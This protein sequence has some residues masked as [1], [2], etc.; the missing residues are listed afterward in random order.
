REHPWVLRCGR[1][2]KCGAEFHV[3]ELYPDLFNDWSR[4]YP[5]TPQSA[6]ATADAYLRDGRGFDLKMLKG[7]YTQESYFDQKTHAAS[8]T[9]RFALGGDIAWERLI[10]RPERFGSMKARFAGK[11]GGLWWEPPGSVSLPDE[12][13]LC[14]GIFDAI[15]LLHNGIYAVSIMS[16]GNYPSTPLAAL[17][18]RCAAAKRRRPALIWALDN[19]EAGKKSIWKF[20]EKSRAEGWEASAALP[21]LPSPAGG[22]RKIDWN[23]L[24]QRDRLNPEDIARYRHAGKVL[25]SRTPAEKARLLWQ[26]KKRSAFP[27]D[28]GK[29]LYWA[30]QDSDQF[31]KISRQH[32]DNG[33]S[34]AEAEEQAL[35]ETLGVNQIC[36][37]LPAPLYYLANAVSGEAWYYFR[38]EFPHDGAAIKETFSPAQLSANAEFKKRMLSFPGAVWTGSGVQLDRLVEHWT[39]DI[40]RVETLDFLGYSRAHGAYVFNDIAVKSG[41]IVEANA[42]DY[43][44]IGKTSI[45]AL[46]KAKTLTISGDAPVKGWFDK[47]L[48]SFGEKGV[49]A[50]GYWLGGLF[51]EQIRERFESFPFL[52][53]VGEPGSGKT[54][55]L[56]TLWKLLGR[57]AY[58]GFDPMKASSVG[59][60]RTMAQFA[61]LPVVLI[62]SD[63]EDTDGS[64]GRA[65]QQFH[66]DDLKSLYNGGSLRTTGV[67]SGGNDT[68]DPQFRAALV[69]SQNNAVQASSA[70]MERILHLQ[71][72]KSHQ[73]EA[74]RQ[75]A[76]DL[77]R[78][79]VTE[80]SGWILQALKAE[81]QILK[82]LETRLPAYEKRLAETGVRNQRLQKNYAMV[83]VMIEALP[84]ILSPRPRAG[85]G[86]GEM[87]DYSETAIVLLSRLALER[88]SDLGRD[89]PI[90][91]RF[92][93]AYEFLNGMGAG[94]DEDD[95]LDIAERLNHSRDA[96]LIA[97]NLNHF[98]QIAADARQQIPDLFELKKYLKTSKRHKFVD[99]NVVVSSAINAH[100]NGMKDIHQIAKPASIRCWVFKA[101]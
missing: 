84:H 56:E 28:F 74:G 94:T 46:S 81:K 34:E 39:Y 80:L 77:G 92:W 70:I 95:A 53:I 23:D 16:S 75:A 35:K 13:W 67:K 37:C 65:R 24:H 93:E 90:V 4:L 44:D 83:M 10:D 42:E 5:V 54:T 66:W 20:V 49:I 3:K 79:S 11:Y 86:P 40:K 2:N 78:L 31:S 73:S 88:E 97:I 51:A 99:S 17:I 98:V 82:L 33:M 58:E 57:A 25:L 38:V 8:A 68:Y 85:E 64:R 60:L 26:D 76:T 32:I 71:F 1:L 18:E 50:L 12:I 43:F 29:R 52:E 91:E 7:W 63:R 55:L 87:T 62:E 89:H 101:R 30:K 69:I 6:T 15:A 9:V 14:E 72:D 36:N 21:A 41:K 100:Y 27:F 22:E 48:T 47:F 96:G 45:R 61:N 19:D 59:F